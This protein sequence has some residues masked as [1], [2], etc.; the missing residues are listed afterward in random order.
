MALIPSFYREHIKCLLCIHLPYKVN[1]SILT[2]FPPQEGPHFL[3]MTIQIGSNKTMKLQ[4]PVAWGFTSWT[5]HA[6]SPGRFFGEVETTTARTVRAEVGVPSWNLERC[7]SQWGLATGCR[8]SSLEE[9]GDQRVE[10]PWREPPRL[11]SRRPGYAKTCAWAAAAA[12]ASSGR[13]SSFSPLLYF[14]AARIAIMPKR[15]V[16][17]IQKDF[18]GLQTVRRANL[19]IAMDGAEC[20]R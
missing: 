12:A 2:L 13:A 1:V 4:D 11:R 6:Q 16:S 5:G 19:A 10:G 9:R 17:L 7:R 15:K 18:K 14:S 8:G 3:L 20:A